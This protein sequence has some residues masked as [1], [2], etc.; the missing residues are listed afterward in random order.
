MKIKIQLGSSP[1]LTWHFHGGTTHPG[2]PGASFGCV[3]ITIETIKREPQQRE[4]TGAIAA[5]TPTDHGSSYPGG[6]ASR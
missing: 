6:G 1:N 3:H 5:P 4:T 2:Q